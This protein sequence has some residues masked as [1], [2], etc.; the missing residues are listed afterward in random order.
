MKI[1]VNSWFSTTELSL[2]PTLHHQALLS[3]LPTS[4][5]PSH[6]RHSTESWASAASARQTHLA[7]LWAENVQR[8]F[9]V[10]LLTKLFSFPAKNKEEEH[11]LKSKLFT[12]VLN[13]YHSIDSWN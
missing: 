9:A 2:A 4:A 5:V 8:L 1:W 11:S 10:S 13:F 12:Y 7:K 3:T 6:H